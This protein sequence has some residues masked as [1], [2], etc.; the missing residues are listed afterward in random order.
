MWFKLIVLWWREMRVNVELKSIAARLYR[1]FPSLRITSPINRTRNLWRTKLLRTS[2]MD[3]MSGIWDFQ[4]GNILFYPQAG[5]PVCTGTVIP[6]CLRF[7]SMPVKVLERRVSVLVFVNHH[8]CLQCTFVVN[9]YAPILWK[10]ERNTY[11]SNGLCE[12]SSAYQRYQ[13]WTW[14]DLQLKF[15]SSSITTLYITF[16]CSHCGTVFT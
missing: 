14:L 10:R 16:Y 13:H 7:I 11:R 8:D 6:P 9:P 5:S 2:A 1:P 12:V 4:V 3:G 15:Q